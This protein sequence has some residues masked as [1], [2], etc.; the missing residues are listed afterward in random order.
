MTWHRGELRANNLV[1]MEENKDPR[2][3]SQDKN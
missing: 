1:S 2:L 3:D